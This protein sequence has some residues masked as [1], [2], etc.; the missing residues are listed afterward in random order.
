MDV[1]G[2]RPLVTAPTWSSIRFGLLRTKPRGAN[3]MDQAADMVAAV[4]EH[5][6]G[7]MISA[8]LVAVEA[9]QVYPDPN[10]TK[11]ETVAKANDLMRLAQITGCI[12]GLAHTLNVNQVVAYLPAA[13][14]GQKKKHVQHAEFFQQLGKVPAIMDDIDLGRGR[15]SKSV[16]VLDPSVL[17]KMMHHAFD[18]V[19]MAMVA[20]EQRL[21]RGSA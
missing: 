1:N 12:Q 11:E 7:F 6:R 15:T 4:A 17:P 13:W 16:A 2:T 5:L 20:S 8:N 3:H 21:R 19:C 18:S 10:E 9:Q 14:K